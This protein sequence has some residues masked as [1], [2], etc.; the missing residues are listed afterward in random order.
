MNKIGKIIATF[1]GVGVVGFGGIK[2]A[3]T[4]AEELLRAD[5]DRVA[6]ETLEKDKLTMSIEK[7]TV[8]ILMREV[9]GTNFSITGV[10]DNIKVDANVERLKESNVDLIEL[11]TKPDAYGSGKLIFSNVTAKFKK[12]GVKD[13]NDGNVTI[14]KISLTGSNLHELN[15]ELNS[16]DEMEPEA[17]YALMKKF[18]ADK[19]RMKNFSIVSDEA[20]FSLADFEVNNIFLGTAEELSLAKV[21]VLG[22]NQEIFSLAEMIYKG[23]DFV[24]AYATKATFKIDDILITP[25]KDEKNN[26]FSDVLKSME[27][28][29]LSLDMNVRYDWDL[30]KQIIDYKEISFDVKDAFKLS[31]ATKLAG[32]P[33]LAQIKEIEMMPTSSFE[34][35]DEIPDLFGDVLKQLGLLELSVTVEDKDLIG[36]LIALKAQEQNTTKEQFVMGLGM[37]VEQVLAQFIPA[38]KASEVSQNLRGLMQKG[39]I[40][41]VG[42]KSK[43]E[44]ALNFAESF[45]MALLKPQAIIEQLDISSSYQ[46]ASH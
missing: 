38:E 45:P 41:S 19:L 37:M 25:P 30:A 15:E 5:F 40:A 13:S 33:T 26:E 18:K 9:R 36:K 6:Q 46:A 12:E 20:S 39:G 17:L 8:D 31:L 28:E 1:V 11:F 22:K 3:E 16:I 44:T 29:T 14:E 2:L 32:A 42:L 7:I 27:L 21:S 35:I 43:D 4:K 34:N 10:D 23:E 24:D